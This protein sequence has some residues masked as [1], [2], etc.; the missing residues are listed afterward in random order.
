MIPPRDT[1]TAQ[2]SAAAPAM[3]AATVRSR[4]AAGARCHPGSHPSEL[5]RSLA[6][7]ISRRAETPTSMQPKRLGNGGW[8]FRVLKWLSENGLSLEV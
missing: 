3:D 2:L 6:P 5:R 4:R 8:Y 1:L 7:F